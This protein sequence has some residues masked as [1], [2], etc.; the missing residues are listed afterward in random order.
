MAFVK[1]IDADDYGKITYTPCEYWYPPNPRPEITREDEIIALHELYE[2][3]ED[4]I[5]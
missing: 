2:L 1:K 3:N 4:E 5:E